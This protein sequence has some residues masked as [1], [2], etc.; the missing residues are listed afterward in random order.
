MRFLYCITAFAVIFSSSVGFTADIY[1]HSEFAPKLALKIENPV[2]VETFK[3]TTTLEDAITYLN[4]Q[5]QKDAT[6]IHLFDSKSFYEP[7]LPHL[8]ELASLIDVSNR[9]VMSE[10]IKREIYAQ[11]QIRKFLGVTR[12]RIIHINGKQ[13]R[14]F[15]FL[16]DQF[17]NKIFD[18][19][20]KTYEII[21]VFTAPYNNIITDF[22]DYLGKKKTFKIFL[23]TFK[24]LYKYLDAA[25]ISQLV[26]DIVIA[27]E[28]N[29][30]LTLHDC[31]DVKEFAKLA[32]DISNQQQR[33]EQFL[34]QDEYH[35]LVHRISMRFMNIEEAPVKERLMETLDLM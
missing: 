17:V 27:I 23:A 2:F 16:I 6:I 21:E 26:N 10:E 4:N 1:P 33:G 20:L 9:A 35:L 15:E 34:S 12:T 19:N 7:L 32:Y 14:I 22:N 3:K 31:K 13:S 5:F 30:N 28:S 8:Q 25:H 11:E 29:E 24:N 18:P